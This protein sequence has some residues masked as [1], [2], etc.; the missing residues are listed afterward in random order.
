VFVETVTTEQEVE[1][2]IP[3]L[4]LEITACVKR[5][6]AC[7]NIILDMD[8]KIAEYEAKKTEIEDLLG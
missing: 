3:K 8:T 1:W 5:K 7:E 2:T 4:N 6:T